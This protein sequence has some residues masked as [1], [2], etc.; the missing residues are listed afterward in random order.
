MRLQSLIDTFTLTLYR[1]VCR[2]L[3]EA[4]K[5]LLSLLFAVKILLADGQVEQVEW[6]FLITG[7]IVIDSKGEAPNP[8]EAWLSPKAWSDILCLSKLPAFDRLVDS[9]SSDPTAW[10]EIYNRSDFEGV[11]F[12]NEFKE[13]STFR[14]LLLLRVLRPDK[15]T[16][17]VTSFVTES[18][19]E[20]Y[21]EPPPFDLKASYA[22]SSALV[23]LVLILSP[24][25]DPVDSLMAF[26]KEMGFDKKMPSVSLGQ[27]QGAIAEQYIE[28]ALQQGKWVLLQ[29]CH[30]A[31]SWLP[32][33]QRM[34]ES[35]TI[36]RCHPHY[37][38]WLTSAPT[39]AF[40][41]SIL[42]NSIKITNAAPKGLKA[43]MLRSYL[44]FDS[45]SLKDCR[46]PAEFRALLFGL[47]FFHAIVQERRKFGPLGWNISYEFSEN[48]LRISV[49][50]LQMF[51]NEYDEIV[52]EA[53][54]YVI[55]QV[56]YG[57]RVTDERDARTVQTILA[58]IFTK[59]SLE[60]KCAL[61]ESG[62]YFVPED[63]S[64]VEHYTAH[65]KALPHEDHPEVFG[66]HEN[67][68]ILYSRNETFELFRNI[69]ALQPRKAGAG[70]G[71]SDEMLTGLASDILKRLPLDYNLQE[72]SNSFPMI[73]EESMNIVLIQDC[74]RYTK[75]TSS[76]RISLQNVQK[77]VKGLIVMSAELEQVCNSLLAGQVPDAWHSRAYP[78]LKPLG[79]WVTDLL[80]RLKFLQD[81]IDAAKPP[82]VFWFPGFFFPQ[83]FV[84]GT[85]QNYS[86]RNKVAIDTLQLT[87]VVQKDKDPDAPPKDGCL[88]N[89]LFLEGAAWDTTQQSLGEAAAKKLADKMPT[90]WFKPAPTPVIVSPSSY[91]CP[92]YRT[93]A[94]RGTLSTTGHSTNFVLTIVL[95]SAIK[96][97]KHWIRRGVA[98]LCQLSD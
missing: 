95:P 25:M 74:M 44:G 18:L 6:D 90:I 17:M 30:L 48:D 86:R 43:N 66:L 75:L 78:S 16:G 88:I 26:A 83:S 29:N 62:R 98:L 68:D 37:R 54:T 55:G 52:W 81:W 71:Q 31:Q 60:P 47:C 61:S 7:G 51:L 27:G 69:L 93:A 8:A 94:R 19:G 13:I 22:D 1:T 24:G 5:L 58:E 33:L 89:G 92:V 56:N 10:H 70:G 40:P 21:T 77:A 73:Y 2:S 45:S 87:F 79:S 3:F 80:D 85:L 67:A 11:V 36:D 59:K 39:P 82:T 63:K 53:L 76:I 65:I 12:P 50:Q 64:A 20:E 32:T 28:E 9:I 38:M 14:K 34:V 57:G 91:E 49:R 97:A 4:H 46:K 41:V 96:P 23:P 35:I 72:L 15:V 42:Q 84:T